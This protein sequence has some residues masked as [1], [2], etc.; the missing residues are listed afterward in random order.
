MQG[1][2]GRP[3][4]KQGEDI[5]KTW[6]QISPHHK[7]KLSKEESE[8]FWQTLN[9]RFRE[10]TIISDKIAKVKLKGKF[11]TRNAYIGKQE[12]VTISNLCFSLKRLEKD[13]QIQQKASKRKKIQIKAEINDI[14]RRK[15][16]QKIKSWFQSKGYYQW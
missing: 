5:E 11:I 4:G 9:K 8:A 10:T 15:T 2:V 12:I 6:W 1:Q 14:E 7:H 13:E 3:E 16:V